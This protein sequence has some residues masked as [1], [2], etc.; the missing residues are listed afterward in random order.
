MNGSRD[1]LGIITEDHTLFKLF[2]TQAHNE[3]IAF[4]YRRHNVTNEKKKILKSAQNIKHMWS[5]MTTWS[6]LKLKNQSCTVS[7]HYMII[8]DFWQPALTHTNC[9]GQKSEQK[10]LRNN[11]IPWN[12]GISSTMGTIYLFIFFNFSKCLESRTFSLHC[13]SPS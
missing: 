13:E 7:V 4:F 5:L 10:L 6:C 1:K 11:L 8:S 3:N 9:M 2:Q 12:K